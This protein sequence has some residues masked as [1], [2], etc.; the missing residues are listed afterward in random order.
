MEASIYRSDLPVKKGKKKKNKKGEHQLTEARRS[1]LSIRE[2]VEH[3]QNKTLLEVQF[4]GLGKCPPSIK[5]KKTL[6][7]IDPS[8]MVWSLRSHRTSLR[9]HKVCRAG[10]TLSM[11]QLRVSLQALD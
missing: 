3:I 4:N 10:K 11:S 8:W 2:S 6:Y 7:Y 1:L 5:T 9:R